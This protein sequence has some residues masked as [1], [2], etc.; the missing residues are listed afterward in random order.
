MGERLNEVVII[1]CV[2]F[3]ISIALLLIGMSGGSNE[4]HSLSKVLGAVIGTGGNI[5]LLV[6]IIFIVLLLAAAL[7]IFLVR[8]K[9]K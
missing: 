3:L 6:P 2:I 7:A 9:G 1:L 8:K 5:K 4:T